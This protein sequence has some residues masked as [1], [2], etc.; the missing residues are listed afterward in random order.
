MVK[1]LEKRNEEIK[2]YF[3]DRC[4]ETKITGEDHENCNISLWIR[5]GDFYLET[6]FIA[7]QKEIN[8]WK[9]GK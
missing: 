5:I 4:V 2:E 8:K 6:S 7:K 1:T 9:E 3:M